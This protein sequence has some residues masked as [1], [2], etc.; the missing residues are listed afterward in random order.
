MDPEPEQRHALLGALDGLGD[1][2][3][4]ETAV[5][6]LRAKLARSRLLEVR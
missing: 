5:V 2:D 6:R 3:R 4:E 1:P